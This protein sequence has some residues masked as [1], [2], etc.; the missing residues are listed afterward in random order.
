MRVGF[1]AR[2]L[3]DPG[4]RGLNRYSFCLLRALENI[5]DVEIC[6]LSEQRYPV[7][8]FYTSALRAQVT[9]LPASRTLSWEQWV[10]P[11]YL[12]RL[13]PD[14]FHA[15]ADGGLPLWKACPYV[16][17]FHGVPDQSLASLVS[18]GELV[19]DVVDYLD[20]S[21]NGWSRVEGALQSLRARLL[22]RVYLHAAD[23]VITVSE[24]SKRELVR[25]MGL[26]PQIV[27]VIH[28]AADDQ[29]AEALP[30][31]YLHAVR[32]KHRIPTRFV[33]FVGG[34]DQRKNVSTL[35]KAFSQVRRAK[36][37][38]A[39]V[40]VGIGGDMEG[41]QRQAAALGLQQGESIFFL[42]RLPDPELA[43]LY[44]TAAL[45]MTLSWHEG[46]CLPLVEAMTCGAPVLA[47]PFG[48]IP[49]ILGDGGRLVDPRC[50]D[51]VVEVMRTILDRAEVQDELRARAL[52][53]S[54]AFSWQKTALETVTAYSEL[55]AGC[56]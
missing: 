29:F 39:L 27:R 50:P 6:L 30:P 15:P 37:D 56:A 36:P 18:S 32:A 1:N 14:V 2:Y 13:K 24:F 31:R 44:R 23:L 53:R 46:F 51:E 34:F 38:V 11:R 42:R 19:G 22:R 52:S 7:H 21:S 33:L 35:L 54:K 16:L 4:L 26:S 10:L 55:C 3:Y 9:N 5:P 47:S 20:M 8:Q 43:A 40:L 25:F 48:A 41:C 17:T 28:E 49:E 45:F 12:G